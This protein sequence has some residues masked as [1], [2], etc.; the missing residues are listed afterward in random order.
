MNSFQIPSYGL[1]GASAS[2]RR[3][4]FRLQLNVNNLLNKRYFA[5]SYDAIY[6]LPGAPRTARVTA[7]WTF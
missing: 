7:S 1:A 2:Y 6:V 3:G 4:R 5:G